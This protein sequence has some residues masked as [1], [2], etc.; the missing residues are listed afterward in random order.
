MSTNKEIEEQ[1]KPVGEAAVK[2][3][4]EA[5]GMERTEAKEKTTKGG[6]E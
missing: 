6:S 5:N 1:L 2:K 4:R 3:F